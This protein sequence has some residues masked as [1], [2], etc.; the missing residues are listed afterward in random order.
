MTYQQSDLQRLK[1]FAV[2]TGLSKVQLRPFEVL[3]NTSAS[4]T[5]AM[6]SIQTF[7]YSELTA[8]VRFTGMG[9]RLTTWVK[10][11]GVWAIE[12]SLCMTVWD[13]Y[14]EPVTLLK[15]DRQ[16]QS[17]KQKMAQREWERLCYRPGT[18]RT[19]LDNYERVLAHPTTDLMERYW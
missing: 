12:Q 9:T 7:R 13:A 15:F 17:P 11:D 5:T 8:E 2:D 10:K 16:Y 1:Q 3:L 6:V 18:G 19:P 4:D 14:F